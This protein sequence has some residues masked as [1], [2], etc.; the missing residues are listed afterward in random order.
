[1]LLTQASHSGLIIILELALNYDKQGL[2]LDA[3]SKA[4]N[5]PIC[6]LECV[7]PKLI[8][9]GIVRSEKMNDGNEYYFLER[10]PSSITMLDVMQIF[11][12]PIFTGVFID[13]ASGDCLKES[14]L[15][16]IVNSERKQ[17]K[18]YLTTRFKKMTIWGICDEIKRK[19]LFS[20]HY[21][22][23]V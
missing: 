18:R 15:S 13:E 5:I 3:I 17:V 11:E 8:Q 9:A 12:E 19:E 1:M 6:L 7:A 20:S 2:T 4:N 22:I 16:R 14:L 21:R 10:E 23:G